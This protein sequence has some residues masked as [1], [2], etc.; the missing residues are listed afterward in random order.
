MMV[1]GSKDRLTI[2]NL[3]NPEGSTKRTIPERIQGSIARFPTK[4]RL[5]YNRPDAFI[6]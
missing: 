2:Q 3:Q 4:Q 1:K 5:T 6:S